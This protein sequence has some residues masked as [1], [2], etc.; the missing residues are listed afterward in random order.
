MSAKVKVLGQ[1]SRGYATKGSCAAALEQ[2]SQALG[3][4]FSIF[5]QISVPPQQR[6]VPLSNWVFVLLLRGALDGNN[7]FV[8]NNLG[9][10]VLRD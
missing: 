1:I 4:L 7:A 5:C 8:C 6:A 9:K 10:C 2:R 3:G